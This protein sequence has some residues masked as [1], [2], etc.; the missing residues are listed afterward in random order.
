MQSAGRGQVPR[1]GGG[2]GEAVIDFDR[3]II[4]TDGACSGNPGPGG[5][6]AVVVTPDGEV[7]ELGAG[8]RET[9]NNRME[10][11]ATIRALDAVRGRPEPVDLY[12]DSTYV[13]KGITQWIWGWRK[14]GWKT[15][16]GQDVS[17][18]D[19][20]KQLSVV[21]SKRPDEGE[22]NWCYVRGH[23]GVPGNERV[24]AI[25]VAFTHGRPA[26]LFRGPLI[27]YDVAI[28]D[29]PEDT[30]LPVRDPSKP[31]KKKAKAYS[32]L[33][34]ID[35]VPMRHATWPECESRVKGQSGARFK[36]ALSPEDELKIF[37]SW[38]VDPPA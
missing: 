15:A 12:T 32:Y 5:W 30:S 38:G 28:H 24:D 14:R 16:Q 18:K 1:F 3:I 25:A 36:K 2:P 7:T 17:N 34:V 35:G 27:R 13:I 11:L 8:D 31:D 19:L 10:L 22:I 21:V 37:E 29:L 6:G 33:S 23:R 4:F 20:W 26:R 9:T